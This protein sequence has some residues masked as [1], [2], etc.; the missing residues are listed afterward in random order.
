MGKTS[1]NQLM[2]WMNMG[3]S[4]LLNAKVKTYV[5]VSPQK[6][7]AV[8][9]L[10][11]WMYCKKEGLSEN[12]GTRQKKSKLPSSTWHTKATKIHQSKNLLLCKQQCVVHLATLDLGRYEGG[13]KRERIVY[14][15]ATKFSFL[16]FCSS[17]ACP[18]WELTSLWPDH[19]TPAIILWPVMPKFKQIKP[20]A[21][22]LMEEGQGSFKG[23]LLT[24]RKE[25]PIIVNS[26]LLP[27]LSD[28]RGIS[29]QRLQL[30]RRERDGDYDQRGL[31][32]H[33]NNCEDKEKPVLSQ[34]QN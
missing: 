21:W 28:S 34:G 23:A 18:L 19:S 10:D 27:F 4:S 1:A 31:K 24:K 8:H 9:S 33:R 30:E 7:S 26:T 20:P 17:T 25:P 6:L 14:F 13:V 16:L 12:T 32:S 5:W 2:S 11:L 3:N 15:L 29:F 22:P